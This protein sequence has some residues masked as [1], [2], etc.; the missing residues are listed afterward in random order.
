YKTF[1]KLTFAIALQNIIVFSVN[2]A[3]NI[4]IGAYSETAMAAIALVNQIHFLMTMTLGGLT[5]G[6][7]VMASR[8][9]GKKDLDEVKRISSIGML[10]GC[11]FALLF[12]LLVNIFPQFTLKLLT[13]DMEIIETGIKYMRIASM[14]YIFQTI[15]SILLATLRSVE[16]VKVGFAVNI[17]ALVINISLNYILIFG[18]FGFP[19]MGA[20]GAAIATLIARITETAVA[21]IYLKFFDK[22]LNVKLRS[23]FMYQKSLFWQFLKVAMPVVASGASWGI[24]MGVQTSILGHMGSTTIAAN[25]IATTVFQVVTVVSNSSAS[26]ASVLIGKTIGE[27]R[28]GMVKSYAKTL[29]ILFLC[30]GIVTGHTLFFFKDII[31]TIYAV[32][33]ETRRLAITFMTILSVTSVGSAY[34]MPCLC[35]IV[36][37]GGDTK[38]VFIND[39]I[40]MWGIVLPTSLIAAYVLNLPPTIVFICLKADQI[41]KCFVAIFKV[42]RFKWIR[43]FDNKRIEEV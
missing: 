5:E 10:L 32:S 12:Y 14:T 37:G 35:G 18:K 17:S 6:V 1:F 29:Q 22:K 42:N 21:I 8:A 11:S 19:E 9:W 26:G 28:I 3:D 38:F 31:I 27:G 20:E 39:L 23:F 24:A 13:N 25:S 40:F 4:M 41:L 30:I 15:T 33:V 7:I 43:T 34:Q 16:T 36:R 2:L